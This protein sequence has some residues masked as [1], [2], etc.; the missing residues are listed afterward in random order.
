MARKMLRLSIATD[1][2]DSPEEEETK[3][4]EEETKEEEVSLEKMS[5]NQLDTSEEKLLAKC[6]HDIIFR[7]DSD[8]TLPS[9]EPRTPKSHRCFDEDNGDDDDDFWM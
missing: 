6:T 2:S 9:S 4:V 7:D 3:E 1:S 5:M 8:T